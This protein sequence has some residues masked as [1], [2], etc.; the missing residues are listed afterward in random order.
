MQNAHK[1]LVM[2][3]RELLRHISETLLRME[4]RLDD[5]I[6][7]ENGTLKCLRNQIT[8]LREEMAGSRVKWA[9]LT[10]FVA[11]SVSGA[12]AWIANGNF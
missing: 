11:L 10:A 7:E 2:T 6:D 5:H 8:D 4:K 1:G 12:F 3:E 9:T